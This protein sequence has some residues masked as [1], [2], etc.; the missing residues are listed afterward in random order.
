M[1]PDEAEPRTLKN[2]AEPPGLTNAAEPPGLAEAVARYHDRAYREAATLLEAVLRDHPQNV[3]ALRVLGLCHV[4]QGAVAAGMPLLERARALAPGDPAVLMAHGIGLQAAG[5]PGDAARIFRQ[6]APL[7][8][9]D[10][11]PL[12]NLSIALLAVGDATGALSAARRAKLRDPRRA[13]AHYVLG[14]AERARGELARA[15]DA[16]T[17]ATRL[18]TDFSEAW[19][20][21]G[22]VRY[23]QGHLEEAQRA[24]RQA[25]ATDPDNRAANVNLALFRTV[26]E[27][28]EAPLEA[29]LARDPTH[30]EVRF[31]L[32]VGLVA[33]DR[34]ADALALLAGHTPEDP[35]LAVR[36]RLQ[37]S[38]ILLELG[39]SGDAAAMLDGI[40]TTSPAL[41]PQ[42]A[43]RRVH[44][45]LAAG[46][47][48]AA[49]AAAEVMQRML[50]EPPRGIGDLWM[51]SWF[52]LARF[53]RGQNEWD[54]DFRC[55]AEG[56][57]LLRRL[58]PFSRPDAA[59]FFAASRNCF[60]AD[61]LAAGPLAGNRDQGPVFIVG[62]PRSG[63]TLTEQIL[64]SHRDVHGGGERNALVGCFAA[65]CGDPRS[66][67]SVHRAA[68]LGTP[69]LDA[70]AAAYLAELHALAPGA[71]VITDK[72]PGNFRLL[73]FAAAMLPG[74]R[75][76][77]CERDPRDIGLSIFQHPFFGY[78]PYAHDLAD[79]GWFIGQCRGMMAHWQAALPGRIEV[80]RLVDWV[81]DFDATLHRLLT[82]LDLPADPACARFYESERRVMTV[83]RRQVRSPLNSDG[84]D[85]WKPY[86]RHLQPLIGELEN[87]KA[88]MDRI[89]TEFSS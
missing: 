74:A 44:L 2:A 45:A 77:Y 78:H 85:R 41:A 6:C 60:S 70:A 68:A 76:V 48:A 52:D 34:E 28:S 58:Q 63:T 79:L 27:Q 40:E 38:A 30:A 23:L 29:L 37:Q 46:D 43:L 72:M 13:E 25:L 16:L 50:L 3:T 17:Q 64:A 10:P 80:V 55:C 53:W 22:V 11:A 26:T 21:L 31:N 39:R 57:R 65:L 8:P 12:L 47:V 69:E 71:A 1:R 5:L 88:L 32:A 7:L 87:D 51:A 35:D 49:R 20:D 62:M 75:I 89:A 19:V 36:W 42:M 81:E 18:Q 73:G 15:A 84:M 54:L 66:A 67:A 9:F 4:R 86:A 83:S 14:L 56:H 61:R 59:A 82:F 33:D 24:T